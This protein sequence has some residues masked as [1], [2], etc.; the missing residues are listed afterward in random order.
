MR[1][2]PDHG[3]ASVVGIQVTILIAVQRTR[4]IGQERLLLFTQVSD[5]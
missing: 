1:R 3:L 4:N 5:P 2:A